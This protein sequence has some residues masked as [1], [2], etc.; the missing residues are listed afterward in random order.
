M[1]QPALSFVDSAG[2]LPKEDIRMKKTLSFILKNSLPICLIILG[3]LIFYWVRNY[4]QVPS[5]IG[6]DF[7][8]KVVATMMISLSLIC[9]A[10]QRNK[11]VKGEFVQKNDAPL[12]IAMV[13]TLFIT[14]VLIMKHIYPLLGIFIFLFAY[15]SLFVNINKLKSL[16]IA[17]IGT[18]I[19]FVMI[20]ALRI[21]M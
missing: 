12:K 3:C 15:L 4:R 18:A 16:I 11:E 21:S 8:P 19:M 17:T 13:I 20:L 6:P 9:I 5:G 1:S 10:T 14:S 2:I 7:F